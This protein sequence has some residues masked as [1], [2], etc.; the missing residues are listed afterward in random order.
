M[1][2][3]ACPRLERYRATSRAEQALGALSMCLFGADRDQSDARL[4]LRAVSG[5]L[6]PR[7][8]LW[9]ERCAIHAAALEVSLQSL[10]KGHQRRCD[11]ACCADDTRCVN[12]DRMHTV[13]TDVRATLLH[14]HFGESMTASL[15]EHAGLL[16]LA[17]PAANIAPPPE[18]ASLLSS[19]TVSPLMTGRYEARLRD[20][21]RDGELGLLF[22][23]AAPPG[24]RCSLTASGKA[25]CQAATADATDEST[26]AIDSLGELLGDTEPSAGPVAVAESALWSERNDDG[27]HTLYQW[28]KDQAKRT[29]GRTPVIDGELDLAACAH[30]AGAALLLRAPARGYDT[31]VT[32]ARYDGSW[33]VESTTVPSSAF[34]FTC[35]ADSTHLTWFE[36]ASETAAKR[37]P[38]GRR[39]VDG[40]YRVARLA[41]SGD[42]CRQEQADVSLSRHARDSR[43]FVAS[44]GADVL[45]LWRSPHGDVRMRLAPIDEVSSAGDVTVVDDSAHGGFAWEQASTE[46]VVR[47]DH[48]F[49]LLD[50]PAGD[51]TASYAFVISDAGV[52]PVLPE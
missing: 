18:P 32:I 11:D 41:C 25:R 19:A 39:T 15:F 50:T 30:G 42:S 27:S 2:W 23:S 4:R 35:T 52:K 16:G 3:L 1:P 10:R 43:Y 7:A 51:R 28:Q 40:V 34:G 33:R 44:L 13:L 45:L 5:S 12:M 38:P 22:R 36:P 21:A 20:E 29:I 46:L 24:K 48:A 37:T 9:P 14:G 8:D 49:L 31:P 6:S 26:S 17:T 47:G